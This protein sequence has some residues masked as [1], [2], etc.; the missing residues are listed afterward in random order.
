V[1]WDGEN[2][3]VPLDSAMLPGGAGQVLARGAR[4]YFD[5]YDS[6]YKLHAASIADNGAI[7]LGDG[8]LVTEQSGSL[9]DAQGLSAYVAIGN[10]AVARYDFATGN[11]TLTDLVPV[12]G[13][14]SRVRFGQDTAYILLGY[15]GIVT[16]PL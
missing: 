10:G 9:V 2:E 4:V 8:V 14:P 5:A 13:W 15:F 1:S 3:V 16:L 7:A 12:M 11:G 6:G